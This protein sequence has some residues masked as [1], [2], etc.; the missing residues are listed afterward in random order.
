MTDFVI[1]HYQSL[2]ETDVC[3]RNILKKLPNRGKIFVVDNGSP[4]GSGEALQEKY[5]DAPDVTIIL[6][7]KNLGFAR[8][9]NVGFREA[10]YSVSMA[11]NP[12]EEVV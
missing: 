3:V 7:G 9:N 6:T 10:I 4:N 1:L 8:G 5:R 12:Y 2:E 11:C